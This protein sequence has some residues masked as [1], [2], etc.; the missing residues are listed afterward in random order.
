MRIAV[1]GAKGLPPGQGGIE[2]YC[3]EVYPRMVAAGHSVDLYARSSYIDS[4]G[5]DRY[6]FCG[7][8][9]ISLPSFPAVKGA[10]A[11]ISSALGTFFA[12]ILRRYDVVHVHALGPALFAW[13]PAIASSAKVV[14]FCHGLDWQRVK[15]GNFSSALIRSGE[16]IAVRCADELVVV[17]QE[18]RR[19]FWATYGRETVYIPNGPAKYAPSDPDFEFVH[20]LGLEP[21]RYLVFLGRLVPEKCP[22]TLIQAFRRLQAQGWKLAVVGGSSETPAFQA[23]LLAL[24]DN[25]PD[26]LFTG[27]LKGRYLA[28]MM[29]G[30]GLFVL[31]SEIEGLPLAMLEAMQ[32]GVPIVASDIPPHR[33]LLGESRGLTFR[34]CDIDDCIS[35]LSW[36][37]SNAQHMEML[38]QQA[39]DYV[40]QHYSWERV[41]GDSFQLHSALLGLPA[42][43]GPV[44]TSEPQGIIAQKNKVSIS[45]G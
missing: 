24:A 13:L 32:E 4:P 6:D 33:Q 22:D 29:R 11:L 28:E 27:V 21:K 43:A 40:R 34:A 31:P 17:S 42:A 36:A 38:A 44:T 3:A 35:K 14:V 19:Y 5:L 18:L 30:A 1:I 45:G 41:V 23:K 15:W 10:D 12:T 2:H 9:V 25:D 16:K 8:R 26:I 7:V 39:Q 20:S 37:M